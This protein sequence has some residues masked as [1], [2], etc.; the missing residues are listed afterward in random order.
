M[1]FT[2]KYWHLSPSFHRTGFHDIGGVLKQLF[3]DEID[4]TGPVGSVDDEGEVEGA[5]RPTGH[6]GVCGLLR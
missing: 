2:L 5:Y 6:P 3:G 4:Q 1:I